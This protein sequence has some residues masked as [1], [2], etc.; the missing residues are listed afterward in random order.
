M[1][2]VY[3]HPNVFRVQLQ[4][5]FQFRSVK[6]DALD[7]CSLQLETKDETTLKVFKLYSVGHFMLYSI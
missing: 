5:K 1:S 4:T 3:I 7:E 2:S 6:A